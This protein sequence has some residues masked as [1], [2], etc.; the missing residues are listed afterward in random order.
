MNAQQELVKSLDSGNYDEQK[1]IEIKIPIT[2]PYPL[3]QQDYERTYGNFEYLGEHYK[4]VKQKHANDTLY[5]ICIKDEKVKHINT[6]LQDFNK[7]AN[8]LPVSEKSSNHSLVKVLKD[9]ET[10]LTLLLIGHEGWMLQS[11]YFYKTPQN[12]EVILPIQSPPPDAY[13]LT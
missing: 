13:P 1:T 11:F 4:L 5:V 8:E 7:R 6:T 2:F 9:Y 10:N 12:V 3:Q